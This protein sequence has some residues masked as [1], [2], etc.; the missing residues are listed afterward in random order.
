MQ[1]WRVRS[2]TLTFASAELE[3][4]LVEEAS[5]DF[6][7]A[8][9]LLAIASKS[10]V[11]SCLIDAAAYVERIDLGIE[12][13]TE[14]K[15][16]YD[17]IYADYCAELITVNEEVSSTVACAGGMRT[18]AIDGAVSAKVTAGTLSDKD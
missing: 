5:A 7:D 8:V 11:F 13:V 9:A 12:G 17:A 2:L 14:A 1:T 10:E 4:R 6:I 18:V 16:T 15:A 3:F